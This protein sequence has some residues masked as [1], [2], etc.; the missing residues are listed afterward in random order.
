MLSCVIGASIVFSSLVSV[1]IQ[2]QLA[3]TS[4][5]QNQSYTE[6]NGS[7][8]TRQVS[9][10]FYLYANHEN[11]YKAGKEEVSL[12]DTFS[13]KPDWTGYSF[14]NPYVTVNY[15]LNCSAL[16]VV[17]TSTGR[18]DHFTISPYRWGFPNHYLLR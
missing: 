8:T 5:T 3:T 10:T 6:V 9:G 17:A 16:V 15:R 13:I 18:A 12:L 11:L 7:T 14:D 4:T 2:A 1:P